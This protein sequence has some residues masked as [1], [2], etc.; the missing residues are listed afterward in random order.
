[1]FIKFWHAVSQTGYMSQILIYAPPHRSTSIYNVMLPWIS[2][3]PSLSETGLHHTAWPGIWYVDQAS[4]KLIQKPVSQEIGL[5]A[6]APP[7][8]DYTN[9]Q[10]LY[11]FSYYLFLLTRTCFWVLFFEF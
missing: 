8:L 4:F 10:I 11:S 1:M 6:S 7:R 9:T 5:K 3:L 2:S